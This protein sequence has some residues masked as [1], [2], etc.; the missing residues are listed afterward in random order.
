MYVFCCCCCYCPRMYYIRFTYISGKMPI[1]MLCLF[2]IFTTWLPFLFLFSFVACKFHSYI[3]MFLFSA[4]KK[5]KKSLYIKY[6]L[7][8][9]AHY[10]SIVWNFGNGQDNNY[11][12]GSVDIER[13]YDE[14]Y[15]VKLF[16]RIMVKLKSQKL[17]GS[18]IWP[19]NKHC[20][21]LYTVAWSLINRSQKRAKMMKFIENMKWVT[22]PTMFLLFFCNGVRVK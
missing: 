19:N 9:V 20:P 10:K 15:A 11:S 12:R 14:K 21:R 17:S 8:F 5:I 4:T 2:S 18:T 1:S 22:D 7:R 3:S 13:L 6:I 16:T